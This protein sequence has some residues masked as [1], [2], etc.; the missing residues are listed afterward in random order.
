MDVTTGAISRRRGVAYVLAL[1][2]LVSLSILGLA[3][4]RVA[5]AQL[6][7]TRALDRAKKLCNAA[8][9]GIEYGYYTYTYNFAD[10]KLPWT[11]SAV[12][13][14]DAWFTVT[15]EDYSAQISDTVRVTATAHLDD[16]TAAETR[17][18]GTGSSGGNVFRYAICAGSSLSSW[19][20][21]T[22]GSDGENGD[23]HVNGD[24]SW[25]SY[26]SLINGD[27]S[28]TGSI[29]SPWPRV[30]GTRTDGA[31]EVEFPDIDLDYYRSIADQ[32]YTK[33]HNFNSGITFP[34]DYCV[35]YV[36]GRS[37]VKGTVKGRG[38]VVVK[39]RIEISDDLTYADSDT[40]KSTTVHGFVYAH[41]DD[42]KGEIGEDNI[43]Y[44]TVWGGIAADVVSFTTRGYFNTIIHDADFSDSDFCRAM[45]LPGFRQDERIPSRIIEEAEPIPM[46]SPVL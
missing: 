38:I 36:S 14:G 40:D 4:L 7:E 8:L 5:N 22:T 35:I 11:S 19:W 29:S 6:A 28:A 44:S 25:S 3:A 15:I 31:D 45:H 34:S 1:V 13:V 43:M 32:V 46:A 24:L 2:G 26:W 37:R 30:T 16:A 9:A 18:Y 39:D 10:K 12:S 42:D 23:V 27:A 41:T 17:V 20:P 21:T 33:N